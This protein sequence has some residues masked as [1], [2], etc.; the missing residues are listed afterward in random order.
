MSVANLRNVIS[1]I[2]SY[3][4]EKSVVISLI[5]QL[6]TLVA[7]SLAL[8]GVYIAYNSW[9]QQV[10]LYNDESFSRKHGSLSLAW[11]MI[12]DANMKK[13]ER[14]QSEAI[15][16]LLKSGRI[17]GRLVLNGSTASLSPG[18]SIDLSLSSFC[19]TELYIHNDKG[20]W[21]DLGNS[22]LRGADVNGRL[23]DSEF[24]G[25]DL[26]GA[27]FFQP[28]APRIDLIGT[29]LRNAKFIGGSF[30]DGGFQGADLRNVTTYRGDCGAG[31][32]YD[33][34]RWDYCS[35][36]ITWYVGRTPPNQITIFTDPKKSIRA[37][38]TK[39]PSSDTV[40]LVDFRGAVFSRADLRGADLSNST[41]TQT[42]VNQAC[43]DE[44]TKL[45]SGVEPNGN[46]ADQ[47]EVAELR[48]LVQE[49][50][51]RNRER[52]FEECK[53]AVMASE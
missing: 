30:V 22:F 32:V 5:L 13:S 31:T 23:L 27:R 9:R 7:A 10:K 38:R 19:G 21:V 12:A 16:F 39:Y 52:L 3:L 45:P 40:H 1:G 34:N 36:W 41:I 20:E 28:R 11:K 8:V 42:Q 14:G 6:V 29:N 4:R 26:E 51:Y 43:T 24:R 46:C 35:A 37:M 17:N 25:S 33:D 2:G 53:R 48:A 44:T 47:Q 15:L 18:R 49:R 50:T